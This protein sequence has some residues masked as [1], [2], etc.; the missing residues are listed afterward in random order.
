MQV[1]DASTRTPR[2]QRLSIRCPA[3]GTSHPAINAI[4]PNRLAWVAADFLTASGRCAI[5]QEYQLL[6]RLSAAL[7]NHCVKR[8][9]GDESGTV[10]E[11]NGV[12]ILLRHREGQRLKPAAA[13]GA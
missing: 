12:C 8:L 4:Y 3:P 10:I 1:I 9:P 6:P 13:E 7:P 11:R 2:P 5:N